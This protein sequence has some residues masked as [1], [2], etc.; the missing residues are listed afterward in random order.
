MNDLSEFTNL[1]SLSKTIRFELRP[2]RETAERIEEFKNKAL[3]DVVKRDEKR[4]VEYI[5]M[6][7][8]LDDYYR[9]FID[10]VL[11]Q[12]I[13]TESEIK[14]AFNVY[15]RTKQQNTDRDKYRKEF[16]TIQKK[17]RAKIAKAFKVKLK[18]AGLDEYPCLID[19]VNFYC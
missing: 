7:T 16:K 3:Y 17:L 9:D 11:K 5:K 1:Y 10:K 14:D 6:K 4:A 12:K 8:I 19:I 18:E 15:K 13:F 2:V